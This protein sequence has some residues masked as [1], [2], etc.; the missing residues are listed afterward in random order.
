[1]GLAYQESQ[2]GSFTSDLANEFIRRFLRHIQATTP[3]NEIVLVL[4]NAP[5]HTKAEDVFDEE[6]F[7][8][9]EVLK[10]GS[11]SPMLNPIGNAFSV[12]KSAVK[13][14][15]AR[16]RPAILRVPEAVTIRVHRSKFLELEA[17][18]LFAEIVTPELCNRTFCHSLPHHQR[19]LRFE[20]MQVGS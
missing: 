8:G 12:Y 10:L 16:Q 3:L 5:C 19:A 6:Q 2:F 11:Y 13:S 15:L 4:D 20:D 1:M 18:P 9:A 7:E 14:F 17:D